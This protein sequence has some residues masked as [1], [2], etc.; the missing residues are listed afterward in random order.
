MSRTVI[1]CSLILI[2][3]GFFFMGLWIPE[4]YWPQPEGAFDPPPSSPPVAA[5]SLLM[6]VPGGLFF[7]AGALVIRGG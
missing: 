3:L 7:G 1:G 2:G 5:A 4:H 6:L